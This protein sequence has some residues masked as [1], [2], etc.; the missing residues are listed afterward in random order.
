MMPTIAGL[1]QEEVVE[2]EVSST[3][4]LDYAITVVNLDI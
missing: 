3:K 1:D 4:H 2:A